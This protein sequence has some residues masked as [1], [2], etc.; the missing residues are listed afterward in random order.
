MTSRRLLTVAATI[1]AAAIAATPAATAAHRNDQLPLHAGSAG[2]R[3]ADLQWLLGGHKPYAFTQVH[4][5]FKG[6]PN[7][8]YGARTKHAVIAM[9]FRV[10]YPKQGQCGAKTTL[11]R[12]TTTRYF[13][14]I[15]E[16][17]APRPRCWVALAAERV[18]GLVRPGASTAALTIQRLEVSQLGVHEIPDGSNLGPCISTT[19]R[20]GSLGLFGPYQG[21]TGAYG[22][23]W[24]AS[25]AQ[26]AL[27]SVTGH[28]I[29]AALPAYVPSIAE[30]AQ[31]HNY[32]AAKPK[33]GSFVI[34]LSSDLRLVNAFHIGY[35][36]RVTASGVQT[37]EGNYANGV[38]EVWR[39]FAANPMVYVDVPG[40]A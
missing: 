11:L 40:V 29:P 7:G 38:H 17:R 20:I 31:Q 30:W 1:A 10:G 33:V 4:P 12:D 22:A 6:K 16:G 32:L 28:T 35:V 2:Q 9:K 13:F 24:C 15:L 3:V 19:C 18:K 25:F 27:K 5:T 14:S 34:F 39:P 23:A 8:S 26:W 21:S 36:V 37:V